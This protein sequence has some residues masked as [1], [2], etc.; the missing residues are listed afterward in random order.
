MNVRYDQPVQLRVDRRSNEDYKPS[1]KKVFDGDGR[2]LGA[3]VPEIEPTVPG[4]FPV[5]SGSAALAS[6]SSNPTREPASMQTKFEVDQS[7]PT[8]SIQIRLADGTRL[9]YSRNS[10][11]SCT[12]FRVEGLLVG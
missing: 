1:K 12:D 11:T 3:P 5:A 9:G 6:S 8:T 4:A 2:R 7:Q 10:V